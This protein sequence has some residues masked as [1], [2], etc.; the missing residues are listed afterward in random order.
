M[1]VYPS[2]CVRDSRWKYILN[3]HPE[4]KFTS[5]ITEVAGEDGNFWQSCIE[6]AKNDPGAAFKTK[7]YQE[8]PRE[9][10]Y[11]LTNDPREENNLAGL[12]VSAEVLN[13][14]RALLQTWMNE[15][16]D[17]S[18]VYGKP[19]LLGAPER[20]ENTKKKS[21]EPEPTTGK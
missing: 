17:Q 14:M 18:K 3:L 11:N 10:L 15:Q 13:R 2:R 7:R 19:K 1:N 12:P 16:R 5:H 20:A 9:E 8:R 4:F 6:K 21:V